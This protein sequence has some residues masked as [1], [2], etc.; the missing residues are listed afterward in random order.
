M[1][2]CVV[3]G[4]SDD[5]GLTALLPSHQIQQ[6]AFGTKVGR[7]NI[8]NADDSK[9]VNSGL[10]AV[11]VVF[12]FQRVCV[13]ACVR[14]CVRAFVRAFVRACVRACVCVR[15]CVCVRVCVTKQVTS[16]L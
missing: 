12:C 1:A 10:M 3:A 4:V 5:R 2:V 15:F 6:S 9:K 13:C 8:A 7:S 11:G 16:M 14:S